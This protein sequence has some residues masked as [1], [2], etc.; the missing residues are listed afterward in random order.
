MPASAHG[1]NPASAMMVGLKVV[2]VPTNKEGEVSK[3]ALKEKV[4]R[5]K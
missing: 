3:E 1:T 5:H 2:E 4:H